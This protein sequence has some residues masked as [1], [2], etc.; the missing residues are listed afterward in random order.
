MPRFNVTVEIILK[1]LHTVTVNADSLESAMQAVVIDNGWHAEVL[2]PLTKSFVVESVTSKWGSVAPKSSSYNPLFDMTIYAMLEQDYHLLP[3]H[4]YSQDSANYRSLLTRIGVILSRANIKYVGQLVVMT[5]ND[6][7]K[8][9]YFG[10]ALAATIESSLASRKLKL[11]TK[12][13]NNDWAPPD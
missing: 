3:P 12:N 11:G 8:L 5:R 13:K 7:F 9:K 4:P 1:R 6:L 2:S 10:D